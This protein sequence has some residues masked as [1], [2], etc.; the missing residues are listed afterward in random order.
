VMPWTTDFV[1]DDQSIRKR[2]MI[3]AAI[4]PKDEDLGPPATWP[5]T[6]AP[7]A[8]SLMATPSAKLGPDKAC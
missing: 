2:R 8:R 1:S 3:M 4:G 7:S 6:T 5:D